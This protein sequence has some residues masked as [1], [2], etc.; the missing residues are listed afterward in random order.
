MAKTFTSTIKLGVTG[1]CGLIGWN[2]WAQ[3][4]TAEKVNF[5]VPFELTVSF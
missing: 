4:D 2:I 5:S 1:S 3:I